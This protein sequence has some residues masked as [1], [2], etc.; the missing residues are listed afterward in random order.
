MI[1]SRKWD[2]PGVVAGV[3]LAAST[4]PLRATSLLVPRFTSSQTPQR[5][6]PPIAPA[7]DGARQ[8]SLG[9]YGLPPAPSG[10]GFL[11]ED[12]RLISGGPQ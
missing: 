5:T 7:T 1:P 6:P 4:Q 12:I 8:E 10:R 9:R 2:N 11:N 3:Y